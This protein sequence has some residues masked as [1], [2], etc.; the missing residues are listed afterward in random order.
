MSTKLSLAYLKS[1]ME[2]YY[3]ISSA[4]WEGLE[5]LFSFR[6]VA[7]SEELFSAGVQP[8]AFAFVVHG[9][10]RVYVTDEDGHEY[11]KNFFQE[12]TFPGC[13][14]AL[15]TQTPSQF[16]I[17]ALE[18][19]EVI[20]IDFKGYRN[21][22]QKDEDL[23]LYHILYLEKNWLLAKDAREV[24]LVQDDAS[25]RYLRF[26]ADYA[27]IFERIPQYHVASHLGVTPTQL[28]R[29][30]KKLGHAFT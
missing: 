26:I 23:K 6:H 1:V 30:R 9:L 10:F 28:S 8:T 3:P 27:N 14:T 7:K 5:S 11:N 21:L 18:D 16:C 15:L 22:L 25:A 29:I 24:Q 17:E 2:S 19:S 13:M 20:L 12:G 4:T